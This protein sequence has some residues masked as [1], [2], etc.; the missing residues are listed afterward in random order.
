MSSTTSM[1][2]GSLFE[3]KAPRFPSSAHDSW[4]R[5][6]RGSARPAPPQPRTFGSPASLWVLRKAGQTD[7]ERRSHDF[8][9]VH[10]SKWLF[11]W[12]R[13]VAHR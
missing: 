5:G 1:P 13:A 3:K 6:V 2:T 10:V 9:N 4:R 11:A 12:D 7:W 8:C